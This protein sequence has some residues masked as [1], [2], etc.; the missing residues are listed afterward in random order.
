MKKTILVIEDNR[1]G[2][3]N[4]GEILALSN[5]SVLTAE[6]GIK[7]VELA[8]REQI[9]LIVCDIMMPHLDGYGVLHMLN[10]HSS[11]RYIPFIF[12]TAKSEKADFRKGMEMGADDYLT[13]PFHGIELLNAIEVRLKKSE[14]V[15]QMAG[16]GRGD[17]YHFLSGCTKSK[18]VDLVSDERELCDYRKKHVLYKQGQRPRTAYYIKKGKVK[19]YKINNDGKE[20]I[21]NIFGEGDFLGYHGIMEGFNY[22][23]NAKVLE[24][25][26]LM[27]IPAADFLQLVT[28]DCRVAQHFIRLISRDVLEKEDD[29]LNQ[30]YNSLRKKVAYG[31]V[32]L[33][34]K[35]NVH[36]EENIIIQLSR[37]EMAQAVGVATESFIRTMA[38]FKEEKL[39]DILD[40]GIQILNEDELKDLAF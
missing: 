1:E 5:Y 30:A 38:D 34:Q 15:S 8:L 40:G 24:D 37:R 4:I 3:E 11:T 7:G 10:Q 9:D 12:L 31:L 29:L 32:Q 14:A 35:L 26:S 23:D 13:K 6:N 22:R 33:K 28:T 36:G 18:L 17:F 27:L 39:I 21:T 19:T 20:L 2:R 16:P 25:A